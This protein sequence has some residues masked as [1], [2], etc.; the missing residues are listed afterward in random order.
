VTDE[1][2]SLLGEGEVAVL[3]YLWFGR[4]FWAL[5]VRVIEDSAART[6]V[7]VAP[8][9]AYRR[10]RRRLSMAEIAANDW[11][12]EE[13]PWV[14]NGTLMISRAGDPYSLWLFWADD[15]SHRSWYVNLELPWRRTERGF[16]TMDLMLDVIVEN[17]RSWRWKDEDELRDSVAAG[18]LTEREV[19]SIRRDGDSVVAALQELLPTGYEDWRP[20]EAW[21]LPELP[22]EWAAV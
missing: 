12:L 22:G 11:T 6:V 19:R 2:A 10:P 20:N 18:L 4:P 21:A 17:D 1:Q 16:E 5:P 9:T 7:W 8:G 14:G 13:F 15:G 3:R